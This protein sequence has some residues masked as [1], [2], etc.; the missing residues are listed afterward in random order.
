L[1]RSTTIGEPPGGGPGRVFGIAGGLTAVGP[2]AGGYLLEWTWRAIFWIN[3]PVALIALALIVISKP[4]TEHRASPMDY[5]GLALIVGG[6]ALSVFGLQQSS[7]WG[8]GNPA[9]EVCIV[10]GLVLLGVFVVVEHRTAS[11]LMNVRIFGN[12]A[13]LVE[14]VILLIVMMAFIPVFF[15][16]SGG[17]GARLRDGSGGVRALGGPGDRPASRIPGHL[18]HHRRG[19]PGPLQ[20]HLLARR[21]GPASAGGFRAGVQDRR[22]AGRERERGYHSAVHPGRLRRRHA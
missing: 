5:R 15:F 19:R 22:A 18:H 9:I 3:V 16:V 1:R 7:I 8:W 6:V 20:H 17:S 4:A 10:A 14:N 2:I 12:R 21:P 11:P 13:F